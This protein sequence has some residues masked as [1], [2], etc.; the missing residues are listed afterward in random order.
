M[1]TS[2]LT[3]RVW[4][5][6]LIPLRAAAPIDHAA[7][8]MRQR[9]TLLHFRRR[10]FESDQGNVFRQPLDLGGARND[11]DVALREPAQRDLARALAVRLPD[12]LEH[13]VLA[14]LSARERAIGRDR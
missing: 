12:A 13:L 11:D 8:R 6:K 9:G 5:R 3:N 7:A 14:H 1:T 10:Q 4:R 2:D